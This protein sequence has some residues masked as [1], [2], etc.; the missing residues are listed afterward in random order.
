MF[1]GHAT[2]VASQAGLGIFEILA[3]CTAAF[4][5][6]NPTELDI[7]L[8]GDW[9]VGCRSLLWPTW[10][11]QG[12]AFVAGDRLLDAAPSGPR[13]LGEAEVAAVVVKVLREGA[14]EGRYDLGS[15]VLM[16][17]HVHVLLKLGDTLPR[18]IAWIKGRTAFEA[19][20]VMKRSGSFWAKDYF[21]RWIGTEMSGKRSSGISNKIRSRRDCVNPPKTGNGQVPT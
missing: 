12:A 21:D 19:N 13:W 5:I 6:G 18:E 2:L 7:A 10:T 14:A 15:W 8:R 20:R 9:R 16:P 1:L 11:T 4:H 17:N 3:E